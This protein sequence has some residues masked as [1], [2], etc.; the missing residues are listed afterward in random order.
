MNKQSM[1][2]PLMRNNIERADL[3]AM[4]AH[5]QQDDPILTNGPKVRQFEAEWSR[6]LGVK[7]SVFVNSGSSANL[8]SLALLKIR[9][10]QGGEVI[11]PPLTWVSDIAAVLQNGFTPV[12]VDINPQTLGMDNQQIIAHVTDQTRAVF[13]THVQGFNALT[14]ELIEE[15]E[16]RQIPL[17]EDVCESH[18]A[19]HKDR[20]L[21]SIGWLSNFSFYYAHHMTTIEGGMICT[22][23][24]T[25]YQQARMLRSHGMVRELSDEQVKTGYQSANPDLNPDFIFSYAAYNVRN[26]ELGAILGLSQLQRLDAQCIRRTHNLQRF[27][28]RLD[29]TKYRTDF[30]LEGSSNYAFNLVLNTA[31]DELA[32]RLMHTM[33]TAGIE[34]RRGS[35]GGG[36]Q[37]RQPYL[38]GIIPENFHHQFPQTEHIHFYGFYIGNFP[39][40]QNHEI[41]KLCAILNKIS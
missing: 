8:L 5:L 14:D 35:A 6:W 26:T 19:T 41:D 34:F 32:Q 16:K 17:I 12:F 15:L 11:V 38:R 23:D 27:L 20:K 18:G 24:E 3:D 2:L 37:L 4:I 28:S 21:G 36:N 29:T 1:T 25:V 22:D 33:K 10:P 7:Y 31:D 9:Y 30:K 13:L 40:L 39:D